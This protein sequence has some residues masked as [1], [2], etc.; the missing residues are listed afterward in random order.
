M[1]TARHQARTVGIVYVVDDHRLYIGAEAG[2]HGCER[3]CLRQRRQAVPRQ[4]RARGVRHDPAT[5]LYV[6]RFKTHR[7]ELRSLEMR[8]AEA[9]PPTLLRLPASGVDRAQLDELAIG[10]Q[11]NHGGS[12]DHVD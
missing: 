4:R 6:V 8:R 10:D 12:V 11:R 9:S 2:V 3:H 1:V 7:D 5:N